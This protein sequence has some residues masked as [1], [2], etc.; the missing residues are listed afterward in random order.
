MKSDLP[1]PLYAPH[2]ALLFATCGADIRPDWQ[3]A[4]AIKNCEVIR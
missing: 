3:T 2:A 4:Q 1:Q